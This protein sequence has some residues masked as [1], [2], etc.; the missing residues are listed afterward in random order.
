MVDI[1]PSSPKFLQPKSKYSFPFE[2]LEV[3]QSF[4][5]K[6]DEIS[7][8]QNMRS[9]ASIA[10]KLLG[11]KFRVIDHGQSIGYE[12]GRLPNKVIVGKKE[13]KAIID[14]LNE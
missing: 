1:F 12:V 8:L 11:R 2:Q 10:S 13:K 7:S 3:G 4:A 5:V 6:Y 9:K 14:N